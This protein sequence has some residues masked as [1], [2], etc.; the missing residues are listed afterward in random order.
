MQDSRNMILAIVLSIAVLF[1]WQYFVAGP[2]MERAAK[3]AEITAAQEA[4][5]ETTNL[6]TP[7]N[8][9]GS[10]AQPAATA[11]VGATFANRDDAIAAQPR[12]EIDT[13]ALAGSINLVGAR[14]D[15]LELKDY[16][17]TVDPDSPVITLLS[18]S[19]VD[20]A[21]FAEQGW[22]A[23]GG[24]VKLPDSKTEWAVDG[25]SRL[26]HTNPVTLTYDNGEGLT[27]RRT[28]AVDDHYLFTVTQT[29]ENTGTDAISIYPYAR[30]ARH[31]TPQVQNFF[32]QHE[33]PLG[34]LGDKNLVSLKYSD[35]EKE[36]Q[37]DVSSTGGWLGITDKYWAT[38]VLPKPDAGINARFAWSRP[39]NL[40]IYQTSF[41]GNTPVAVAPGAT[42]SN[43]SYV[44]AGAKEESVIASY[45]ENFSFDR[46]EL[47][48]DWGW[49]HFITK[50]LFLLLRF[51]Y[52]IL[53][54]F[55]LAILGVTVIIK[56][57][58]FP[59]ASRS[60]ASMAAMRR[61]Q[62]E[63]K[64]LQERFKDDRAGQQQAM[65]ELYKKEKIN[66]ISGCWPVLIQIPV[67]YAL[68]TVLFI[69]LEMRHAPFFG[70]IQDLAAPD[71]TNIFTLFGLIPWDPTVLPIVGHFLALGIWPVIMGL[72]MWVQMKLNPPPT[73]P[74][75]AMIF[76]FMPIIFTFML[77]TFP[78]GLV[79]YWAWNNTLSVTQQ[80]V[81]M[82][83]HGVEV[84]LLGNILSSF[85]RK[86]A[87]DKT[88]E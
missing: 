50:P 45:E 60:Y 55:G 39:G 4:G 72:T 63:M 56:A 85:K 76:A 14:L 27:F 74:S 2:Q 73:D 35:L 64:A 30:V 36:Q 33:G 12:V 83:R 24:D 43:T 5:A 28:F 84:N 62:P 8:P 18:P 22:V 82:K 77:G 80:W 21:Y 71:P 81:I 69:S 59:L 17:E 87:P 52:G 1:G 53:G 16:R 51:L 68:Y 41:V 88:G 15:D 29:V 65:M 26:T 67:F 79:I 10:V 9:D 20:D 25:N 6:P 66:P 42:A 70:W 23:S 44:F 47:L 54:N 34:V 40:N 37:V 58:F 13:P 32:V 11:G 49:L 38:A 19:G 48:I 57:L 46:L 3:Q 31:G 75:Q 7:T 78:A 86:P 61:V